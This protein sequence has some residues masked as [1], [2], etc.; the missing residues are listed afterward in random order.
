MPSGA[1]TALFKQF[2]TNWIDKYETTGPSKP[3]IIGK[4]AT[5]E[6]IPFD[7]TTLHDNMVMAAVHDMVDDGSREVQVW[8]PVQ[9]QSRCLLISSNINM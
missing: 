6:Q 4:I 7:P 1:E 8:A 2:F 3:F 9:L 5:V